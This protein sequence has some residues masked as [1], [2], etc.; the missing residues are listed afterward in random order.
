MIERINNDIHTMKI[1]QQI[2]VIIGLMVGLG[3]CQ[4]DNLAPLGDWTYEGPVV[5]SPQEGSDLVLNENTPNKD[6][7]FSWEKASSSASYQIKYSV[8]IDSADAKD[9][10]QPLLMIVAD[11]GGKDTMASISYALF[12]ETLSM[13]GYPANEIAHLQ[14]SVVADIVGTTVSDMAAMDVK[15]FATEWMP[16][17]L[18]LSGLGAENNGDLS[19]AIA[20]KKL[21]VTANQ[22]EVYTYLDSAT[23]FNFFSQQALPA[24]I[25]GGNDGQLIKAGDGIAVTASG[26]YKVFVDLDNKSYSLTKI[27]TWGVIGSPFANEWNSDEFLSYQGAGV[28]SGTVDFKRT[29]NFI[30]RANSS[31]DLLMK[32]EVGSE[33]SVLLESFANA[34]GIAV[35][36][37]QASKMGKL[38]VTLDLSAGAYTY[39][40][41]SDATGGDPV[42]TPDALFLLDAADQSLVGEFSKEGDVFTS[43]TYFA[44]ESS[45]TYTLNSAQD[46]SGTSYQIDANLGA[47][48]DPTVD[49][50]V[51][52][53]ILSEG[54]NALAVDVDQAYG[55]SID[56]SI[57]ELTWHYYNIKL[58]HWDDANGGWDTRTET[59]FTYSH[60]YTYTVTADMVST[61][62]SKFNSPW[63]VEFGVK[64]G[65]SDDAKALTGSTTN[66]GKDDST[67]V[68]NFLFPVSDGSHSITLTVNPDYV[69]GTYTVE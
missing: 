15:R 48:E 7:E 20:M 24:H 26:T 45:K 30:F 40:I 32:Q 9:L 2:A 66:K 55:F 28:W 6:I 11:N 18:F 52:A 61:Y 57:G 4:E 36:D 54:T 23:Q 56:F 41:E 13:L 68:T 33:N 53:P 1:I 47:S 63:E 42:T 34:N 8:Y 14:W 67:P 37:V 69:T 44:L 12:D 5:I 43:N 38:T 25:Y 60:P 62:D 35:E 39:L 31:W 16:E 58:F 21:L 46:G 50:A 49:K 59:A 29:G 22:Y 10:S 17:Q 64:E 27:D 3:A 65:S 19:Q 51:G